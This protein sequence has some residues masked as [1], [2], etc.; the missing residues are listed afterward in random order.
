MAEDK[1]GVVAQ[2]EE[3]EKMFPCAWC[4]D[5]EHEVKNCPSFLS[6]RKVKQPVTTI[7]ALVTKELEISYT[8]SE[9]AQMGGLA[10]AK[11]NVVLECGR[12][13]TIVAQEA[14]AKVL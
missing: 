14:D 9:I 5:P 3:T 4:G 1:G 2:V 10:A 8:A 13:G 11:A 12:Y 6:I 7:N